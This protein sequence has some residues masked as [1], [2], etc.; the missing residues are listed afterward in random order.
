[1]L[2]GIQSLRV[3]NVLIV[4]VNFNTGNYSVQI[5]V[6][7]SN[8]RNWSPWLLLF[9]RR[10]RFQI[11]FCFI[12]VLFSIFFV[13]VSFVTTSLDSFSFQS[14]VRLSQINIIVLIRLKF[15]L[16]AVFIERGNRINFLF[17][18]RQDIANYWDFPSKISINCQKRLV[19]KVARHDY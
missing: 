16:Y 9:R 2:V 17:V 12:F 19:T 11:H 8:E 15:K 5:V 13:S 4:D 18:G 1:M 14:Q 3:A 10:R 7:K 6:Y